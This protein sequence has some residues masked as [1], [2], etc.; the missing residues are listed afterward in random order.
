MLALRT[1]QD[2]PLEGDVVDVRQVLRKKEAP[3]GDLVR[4]GSLGDEI[5]EGYVLPLCARKADIA[6]PI[7]LCPAAITVI[8][9]LYPTQ[10]DVRCGIPVGRLIAEAVEKV[11]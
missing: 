9:P 7:S 6:L 2:S 3:V 10:A 4:N 11:G 8:G 1:R 5:R